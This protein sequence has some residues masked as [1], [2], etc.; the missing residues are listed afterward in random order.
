MIFD[1]VQVLLG[2]KFDIHLYIV[3]G[4]DKIYPMEE[5]LKLHN[6]DRLVNLGNG[7]LF[8]PELEAIIKH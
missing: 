6:D 4:K 8:S 7:D 3:V 1:G 5:F 2:F